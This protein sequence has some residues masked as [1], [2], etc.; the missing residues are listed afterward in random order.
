[1]SKKLL[2]LIGIL[3]ALLIAMATVLGCSG[4]S[5]TINTYPEITMQN[6]KD[7]CETPIEVHAVPAFRF[8]IPAQVI[9]HKSCMGVEDLLVIAWPGELNEKNLT[10]VKLLALMYVEHQG[11][12]NTV[13]LLKTDRETMAD[14]EG[15]LVINMAF[16]KLNKVI[17][18]DPK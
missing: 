4:A 12:E 9:R 2:T 10:A 11:S 5:R 14:S 18:E 17:K 1:M 15:E 7:T 3:V 6:L 16:Y 8:P 13:S